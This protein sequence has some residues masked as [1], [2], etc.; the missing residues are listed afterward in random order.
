MNEEQV[1]GKAKEVA[2]EVQEHV[3]RM[4]GSREQEAKGHAKEQEGKL[5]KK[6]GDVEQAA[7]DVVKKP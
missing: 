7:K 2:G 5:Q 4:V 3:G 6:V 1:K